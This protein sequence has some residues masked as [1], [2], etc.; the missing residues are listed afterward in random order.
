MTRARAATR[1]ARTVRAA[2][3]DGSPSCHLSASSTPRGPA[4]PSAAALL[5]TSPALVPRT[6]LAPVSPA[7]NAE[8]SARQPPCVPSARATSCAGPSSCV[9]PGG[10][11]SAPSRAPCSHPGALSAA[12]SAN[13]RHQALARSC[14]Q[15][16]SPGP[17]AQAC[18]ARERAGPPGG[19]ELPPVPTSVASRVAVPGG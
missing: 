13:D 4:S 9:A 5:A 7:T 1:S 14:A 19:L 8:R 12:A 6:L 10:V 17:A 16:L 18:R 2:G 3:E 15:P 11:S